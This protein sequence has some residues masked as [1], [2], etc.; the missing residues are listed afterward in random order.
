MSLMHLVLLIA[1][2]LAQCGAFSLVA[3]PQLRVRVRTRPLLCT[4][5]DAFDMNVAVTALNKAVE[6][7]DYAEAARLK[8]LIAQAAPAAAAASSWPRSI[9]EWLLERLESL[10]YRYPTPIQSA[11][12]STER[13]AVLRAPTGAGKTLAYLVPLLAKAAADLDLRGEAVSQTVE[14]MDI[15][16]TVLPAAYPNC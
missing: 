10:S 13:D 16:P 15:S 2:V 1:T 7:E 4:E 9:P 11:A 5:S 12:L 14:D 8:A 3:M 6:A